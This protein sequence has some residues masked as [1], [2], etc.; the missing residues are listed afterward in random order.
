MAVHLNSRGD[1]AANWTS[2]NPTPTFNEFCIETDTKKIKIGDGGTAWNALPYLN[3]GTKLD[4]P[5][6]N[7]GDALSLTSTQLNALNDRSPL[8]S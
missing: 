8:V 7:G 3:T 5:I 6:I 1:T 2:N 4:S